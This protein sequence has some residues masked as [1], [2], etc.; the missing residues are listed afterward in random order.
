M[1]I[2]DEEKKQKK[3]NILGRYLYTLY[4]GLTLFFLYSADN[5]RLTS[6]VDR[7]LLNCFNG[8]EGFLSV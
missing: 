8:D 7:N 2:A 4:I 1:K 3:Q 5:L 6:G